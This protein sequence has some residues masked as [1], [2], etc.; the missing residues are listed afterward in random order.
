MHHNIVF[1]EL[2]LSTCETDAVF[3][4]LKTSRCTFINHFQK[5]K[6][7]SCSKFL[8][9]GKAIYRGNFTEREKSSRKRVTTLNIQWPC[10]E[11]LTCTT[12]TQASWLGH[13]M[14]GVFKHS[15]FSLATHACRARMLYILLALWSLSIYPWHYMYIIASHSARLNFRIWHAQKHFRC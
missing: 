14:S 2:W 7:V 13:I 11:H 5:Q 6:V 8:L 1:K 4:Q 15:L 12:H 10:D 9:R 3:T